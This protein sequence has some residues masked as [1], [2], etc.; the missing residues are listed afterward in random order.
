MKRT[1]A[2]LAAAL[3]EGEVGHENGEDWLTARECALTDLHFLLIELLG[4]D[5]A[6]NPWVFER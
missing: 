2:D 1:Y 6:R 3:E 5:D 4:R